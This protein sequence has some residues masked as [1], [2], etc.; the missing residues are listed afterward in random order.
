[1]TQE[2]KYDCFEGIPQD[3]LTPIKIVYV[4]K[5]IASDSV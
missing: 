1:M 5:N 3:L 4:N 2:T